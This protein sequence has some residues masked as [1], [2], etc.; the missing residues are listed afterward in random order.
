M[1]ETTK[2]TLA[3]LEDTLKGVQ[4]EVFLLKRRLSFAQE[5]VKR[6]DQAVIMLHGALRPGVN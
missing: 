1:R 5:D 4:A 3:R 6:L 2:Q